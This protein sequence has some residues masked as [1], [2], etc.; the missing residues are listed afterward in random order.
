MRKLLILF[1]LIGLPFAQKPTTRTPESTD[2]VRILDSNSM[3]WD[4]T[5]TQ[6]FSASLDPTF[7]IATID[8]LTLGTLL[9]NVV[10]TGTLDPTIGITGASG[11]RGINLSISQ[12]GTALTGTLTGAKFNSRVNVESPSG[13]VRGIDAQAGNQTAGYG[14]SVATAGYFGVT[15]KIPVGAV[16]WGNARGIEINMDLD[17]GTSGN[18]NTITNAY[19]IYGVYNLPTVATYS[20]VTNGYGMFLRNE[21][22]GGTG[23]ML[24]AGFYLDD[25]SHSGGIKGWDFGIDFSG[26]GV[27]SGSFGTAD[28]RGAN[29][30][31]ISNTTDG[32]W[33][34]G[35]SKLTISTASFEIFADT[36]IALIGTDT[37]RVVPTR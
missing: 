35:T 28:I 22:V 1:L 23:Q 33:D 34:F 13:T 8:S 16:T 24:D 6:I 36:L 27:N 25:K 7:N 30:E 26:I 37:V 21:A 11:D 9:G 29:G 2:W 3:G 19:M 20:T 12:T 5:L 31:T 10:S 14:L 4:Q 17:Q 15:N 32:E 18:A